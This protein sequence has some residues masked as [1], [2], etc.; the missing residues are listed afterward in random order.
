M[1]VPV[2]SAAL[3]G[4][5]VTYVAL[6]PRQVKHAVTVL[7]SL[8][9]RVFN[10][11]LRQ[12]EHVKGCQQQTHNINPELR[13][14]EIN[15]SDEELDEDRGQRA[16]TETVRQE[17]LETASHQDED[18]GIRKPVSQ[19]EDVPS[20]DVKEPSQDIAILQA[21]SQ[22]EKILT[23][24]EEAEDIAAKLTQA[25]DIKGAAQSLGKTSLEEEVVVPLPKELLPNC[26][27]YFEEEIEDED[28]DVLECSACGEK[29]ARN[30]YSRRQLGL[31]YK[32][33]CMPCIKSYELSRSSEEKS[34][35][36][37]INGYVGEAAIAIEVSAA[38]PYSVKEAALPLYKTWRDI[39]DP[40]VRRPKV[41]EEQRVAQYYQRYVVEPSKHAQESG[42]GPGWGDDAKGSFE[43]AEE[44]GSDDGKWANPQWFL[45][46]SEAP[47]PIPD[48]EDVKENYQFARAAEPETK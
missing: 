9:K 19:H 4:A 26:E 17:N 25:E 20:V 47:P 40:E 41:K 36:N 16:V 6:R 27:D 12:W 10:A 18:I 21:L 30:M 37:E 39:K 45:D 48:W 1:L 46:P 43:T 13:V 32:R 8:P 24:G 31:K 44:A 35:Y 29:Q 28:E 38:S 42:G 15:V 2:V 33:K 34:V 11:L 7:L 3:I 5:A 22:N 14:R 23:V